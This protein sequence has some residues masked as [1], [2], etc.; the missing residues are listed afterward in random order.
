MFSKILQNTEIRPEQVTQGEITTLYIGKGSKVGKVCYLE[1]L[2][3]WRNKCSSPVWNDQQWLQNRS[4]TWRQCDMTQGR[5]SHVFKFWIFKEYVMWCDV[6]YT[7]SNHQWLTL[8]QY[9]P[10]L[11]PPFINCYILF[12]LKYFRHEKENC[13]NNHIYVIYY[14]YVIWYTYDHIYHITMQQY[15]QWIITTQLK[16]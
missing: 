13:I 6:Y 11:P 8:W 4:L 3:D 1:V 16:K 7:I 2:Q 14:I 9:S 12:I 5:N 10:K 15:K